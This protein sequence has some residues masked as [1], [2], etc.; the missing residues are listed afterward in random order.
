MAGVG[1]YKQILLYKYTTNI[2]AAGNVSQSSMAYKVW[3]EI[4]NV[5]GGRSQVDGRT[6]LSNG[7]EFKIYF[8]QQLQPNADYKI[9]YYGEMYAITGL[10]RI[11]EK[12][13]NWLITANAQS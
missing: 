5:G 13:F 11:N 2:D 3:A 10:Q 12:R 1:E 8:R 9:Q 4:T 7:K 6:T